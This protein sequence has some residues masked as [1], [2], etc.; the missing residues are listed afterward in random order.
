MINKISYTKEYSLKA[1]AHY[2]G[3][4]LLANFVDVNVNTARQRRFKITY[5]LSHFDHIQQQ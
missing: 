5:K 2:S 4:K 1:Y 3:Y